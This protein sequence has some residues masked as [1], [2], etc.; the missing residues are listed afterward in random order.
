MR[1]VCENDPAHVEER[2]IPMYEEDENGNPTQKIQEFIER[3][4]TY[5]KGVI[6]WILRLFNFFGKR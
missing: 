3:I 5:V 1:R 6:D 2:V 4:E